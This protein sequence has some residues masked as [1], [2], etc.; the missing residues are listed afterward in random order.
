MVPGWL[1]MPTYVYSR[2][3]DN[4]NF[5]TMDVIRPVRERSDPYID[6]DG[7]IWKYEES[8]SLSTAFQLLGP[9]WGDKRGIKYSSKDEW[10][11]IKKDEDNRKI[12]LERLK[13]HDDDW[14]EE[15]PT[16]KQKMRSVL[17]HLAEKARDKKVKEQNQAEYDQIDAKMAEKVRKGHYN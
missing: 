14:I 15:K 6:N 7:N 17:T 2:L 11:Q 10:N 1:L 9:G 3:D 12:M 16:G 4:D 8:L 13:S 5:L